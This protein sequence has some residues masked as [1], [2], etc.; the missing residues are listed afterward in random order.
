MWG[1]NR[2]SH[3]TTDA[4][5]LEGAYQLSGVDQLYARAEQA[6]RELAL[7]LFKG[8]QPVPRPMPRQAPG[9]ARL[10]RRIAVRALTLGYLRDLHRFAQPSW[11]AP[12][13]V[14]L[15]AD[16]T[17]YQSE[18]LLDATYGESPLSV[19]AF[20]RVRWG[21]PHGGHAGH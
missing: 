9:A 14:G 20:L 1:R 11:L 18:S 7:L 6:N 8:G 13:H 21:A 10:D 12:V 17:F 5:L 3:G 19:H 16:L 4:Y 2:E 15:G